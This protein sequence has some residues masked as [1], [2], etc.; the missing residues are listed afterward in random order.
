MTASKLGFLF[1]KFDVTF[2][3]CQPFRYICYFYISSALVKIINEI[4]L[5]FNLFSQK[6]L[7]LDRISQTVSSFLHMASQALVTCSRQ[8]LPLMGVASSGIH[9]AFPLPVRLPNT[10]IGFQKVHI[11][12]SLTL[13]TCF[14]ESLS[15]S[16]AGPYESVFI[17]FH[18]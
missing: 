14:A 13:F 1:K 17:S 12:A 3:V 11:L 5:H 15:I 16:K 18:F 10:Q 6:C 2:M 4:D 7:R 9:V 8:E